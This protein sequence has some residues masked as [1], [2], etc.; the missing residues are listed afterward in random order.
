MKNTLL[1]I[2]LLFALSVWEILISPAV[3][4]FGVT[5]NLPV[6]ILVF[7]GLFRGQTPAVIFAF[8]WGIIADSPSPEI[9]GWNGL[10]L[11]LIG[12]GIG[13]F[14]THF[15]WDNIGS[16]ILLAFFA[17]FVHSTLYFLVTNIG[18]PG[19][20]LYIMWRYSLASAVYSAAAAFVLS[21]LL[22]TAGAK[23]MED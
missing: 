6:V 18:D 7:L 14:R 16:Q 17:V 12:A 8:L 2:V 20:V 15:N 21:F 3:R 13:F 23:T 4:I 5:P 11:I 10:I 22:Q 19:R 1:I 9:L